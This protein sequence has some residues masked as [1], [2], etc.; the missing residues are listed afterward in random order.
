MLKNKQLV[1]YLPISVIG[2][3]GVLNIMNGQRY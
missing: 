2:V 3:I 1:H